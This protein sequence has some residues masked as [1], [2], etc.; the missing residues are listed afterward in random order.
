MPQALARKL[1]RALARAL[2][3]LALLLPF[4]LQAQDL[5]GTGPQP[6]GFAGLGT[7][8]DG[9]AIPEPDPHF[10]FPRDHGPHPDF[11]IEWWY[12]TATL[13]GADGRDY[14]IQWTLFRSALAPR[15]AEGW[16]APQIFMG[17]AG[18]T[19]PD[20]HHGAERLA[21]GGIGT[22]GVTATPF[23]AVID[24]WQMISTAPQD[25]DALDALELRA[26][27]ADFAYDLALAATGPLV[28][29]GQ[30]GYSVKS[31]AGQSSYYYS[32][33]FYRVTGTLHLADG[34]IAVTGT[35]WLDREWSSQPLSGDQEGWDWLSIH[36]DDGAR[37]MAFGL[38]DSGGGRFT[39]ATWIGADGSSESYGDGH[40]T[41]A[42]LGTSRVA[43]R[44]IPTEWRLTLPD[45]GLDITTTPLNPHS[46]MATSVPYWEGP[47]AV[48]GSH[49]GRGY[50]EMTG[51]D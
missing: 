27:G 21:R 28:F 48:T 20:G 22:A 35:G 16:E 40:V 8:A 44:T 32:Q 11:R 45:R 43:G 51:Y 1:A 29:H 37:L 24:D 33:P 13:R 7:Q 4:P 14:G 26:R 23:R 10:S 3:L 47:I 2:A 18:L 50:L 6:G 42:P 12:L 25:A 39:S 49:P 30:G 17:H 5:A 41:L 9:F 46:W 31:P 19:T 36:F 34:P 38:R 15:T